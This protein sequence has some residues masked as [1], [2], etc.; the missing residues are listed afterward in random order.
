MSDFADNMRALM[1]RRGWNQ[2]QA[3]NAIG[4][5]QSN[6]GRWLKRETAP[7][8][9]VLVKIAETF[10]VSLDELVRTSGP[11]VRKA[12]AE[13]N[14]GP[15]LARWFLQLRVT[16]QKYPDRRHRIRT[17]LELAWPHQVQEI[18]AWLEN[19]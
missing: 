9:P 13:H 16:W 1:A 7:S 10:G 18:I 5:R 2:K 11:V 17:G 3:A 4:V 12:R 6:V 8:M 14:A 19:K 15:N